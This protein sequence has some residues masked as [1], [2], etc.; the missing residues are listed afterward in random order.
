MIATINLRA[1]S[2]LSFSGIGTSSVIWPVAIRITLDSV[3]DH[4]G[5]RAMRAWAGYLAAGGAPSGAGGDAGTA[6]DMGAGAEGAAD[7]TAEFA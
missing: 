3:T 7:A 5:A 6:V 2:S 4:V 1:T